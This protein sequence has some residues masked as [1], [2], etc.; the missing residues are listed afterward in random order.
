MKITKATV[1]RGQVIN[2]GNYESQRFYVE[3]EAEVSTDKG[4][5]ELCKKT[6]VELE[7]Q[8]KKIYINNKQKNNYLSETAIQAESEMDN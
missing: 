1:G 4:Y 8:V 5:E 3:F 2:T 7:R 6:E